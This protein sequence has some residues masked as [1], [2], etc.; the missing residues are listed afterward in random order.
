MDSHVHT[1][2]HVAYL[3]VC[4]GPRTV[5]VVPVDLT[6]RIEKKMGNTAS[7]PDVRWVILILL[8]SAMDFLVILNGVIFIGVHEFE[9]L[10]VRPC[11]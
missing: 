11:T 6:I 1:I 4:S 10:Q 7:L 5:R 8:N 9:S 2:K 3:K